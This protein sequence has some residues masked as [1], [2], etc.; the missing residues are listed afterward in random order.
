[1][2]YTLFLSICALCL[3]G[4]SETLAH[5]SADQ[6]VSATVIAQE[7]GLSAFLYRQI[8]DHGVVH[9]QLRSV[10]LESGT[11]VTVS[12]TGDALVGFAVGEM[13]ATASK[14]NQDGQL[15]APGQPMMMA[16]K[17][18]SSVLDRMINMAGIVEAQ[19]AALQ[20]GELVLVSIADR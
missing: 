3:F 2:K 13:S 16:A 18:A 20:N 8:D 5:S 15:T 7:N 10:P 4:S 12:F 19:S 6:H 1:M 14:A 17:A 9:A 11:K